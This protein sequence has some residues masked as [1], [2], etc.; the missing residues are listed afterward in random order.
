MSFIEIPDFPDVWFYL[1]IVFIFLVLVQL[2]Y[3][4]Y[5][6]ARVAFYR[7][8]SRKE[9]HVPVSVVICARDEEHNLR[10]NLPAVLE[11]QYPEFEVVV[12]NDCSEDNSD[13]VLKE[14]EQRYNHLRVTTIKKDEKF[15]HGK[16]LALTIGIKAARYEWLL[17]TDA[18]CKP[19]SGSW[20]STMAQHFKNPYEVVLGYGGFHAETSLLNNYI[21]YDTLMIAMQYFG[22]AMAGIPYMGV[23][24]NLAYRRSLFFEQKGFASHR[25]LASGDDDLFVNQVAKKNNT[26]YE[27]AHSAHN[28][29]QTKQTLSGWMKQKKRHLTTG[30]HYKSSTKWLLALEYFSRLGFYALFILLWIIPGYTYLV[31]GGLVL[32]GLIFGILIRRVMTQFNEKYLFLPSFIYDPISTILNVLLVTSNYFSSPAP[33]WK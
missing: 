21:R 7:A 17:L 10:N 3:Y 25:K 26:R 28:R 13:M 33:T 31:L 27:L 11:Q 23:G 2:F 5:F 1:G 4:L 24:R 20:I 6:Y 19:D 32:R 22:F 12:V 9:N 30:M 8:G 29:A 18:D 14:F 16:K 15:T